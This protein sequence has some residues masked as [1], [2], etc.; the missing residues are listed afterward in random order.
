M[1][2]VHPPPPETILFVED[3]AL[4]R[5]D[6]A[7]FLRE[8]GY[9][10]HEASNADE[11]VAVLNSTL[12]IDLVITDVRMT[13]DMDGVALAEWIAEH[14]PGVEVI[15]TSGRPADTSPAAKYLPKPY[16]GR[17]LFELAKEALARQLRLGGPPTG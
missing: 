3:E 17:A 12:A 10:V 7:E 8:C 11:A 2:D 1:T 15:L 4:I 6:M 9:Q 13:G 16:T 5:M 14:R